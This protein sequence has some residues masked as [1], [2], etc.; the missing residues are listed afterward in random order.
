M[1]ASLSGL[2][3][4]ILEPAGIS[5]AAGTVYMAVDTFQLTSNDAVRVIIDGANLSQGSTTIDTDFLVDG[6]QGFYDTEA[7]HA[8]QGDHELKVV[9]RLGAVSS[10]LSGHYQ[11]VATLTVVPLL[12]GQ[13]G[14][15]QTT[16]TLPGEA[17]LNYATIAFED[18]YPNPGDADYNDFVVRY[19]VE[20]SYNASGNLETVP[21]NF[22]PIARGAGYNHALMLDLD[23]TIER[24]RT[25]ISQT[26]APFVGDA[27]V[28]VVYTDLSN[29]TTRTKHYGVD[30]DIPIFHNTRS[31][32]AGFANVYADEEFMAPNTQT[33]VHISLANPELNFLPD[34][35]EVATDKYR[36]FLDV[37]TTNSDIDLAVVNSDDG[38]ID[39]NGYPFG[40]VVPDD[41]AWMLERHHID[42]AYPYF[43]E[44]RRYLS[45]AVAELSPEAE[46]W[47]RA[48]DTAADATIDLEEWKRFLAESEL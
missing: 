34:D 15:G 35:H 29:G 42:E 22:T 7:G 21:L 47:F 13:D 18:L 2:D 25:A 28:T 23:G 37:L 4:L 39:P 5:G 9:A 16:L 10:Q 32:L 27:N 20:E 38:M 40:I 14:C 41:W 8:H 36:V 44:Y 11:T 19:S 24:T 45:G 3:D 26:E 12:G 1:Q 48:I 46:N 43:E 30:D 33:S 31:T 6:F 17:D